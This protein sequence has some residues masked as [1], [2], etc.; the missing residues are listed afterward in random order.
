[1]TITRVG[2][3]DPSG[4]KNHRR[5]DPRFRQ[6]SLAGLRHFYREYAGR[7]GA[8]HNAG[9]LT[10]AFVLVF[11]RFRDRIKKTKEKNMARN[12]EFFI[13]VTDI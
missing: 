2:L 12:E 1:M 5:G 3:A 8:S 7:G 9:A 10:P 11:L 6:R 4:R 13:H